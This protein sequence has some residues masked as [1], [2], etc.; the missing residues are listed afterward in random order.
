MKVA[1]LALFILCLIDES[2]ATEQISCL[3]ANWGD[4]AVRWQFQDWEGE[5]T[6]VW[7]I[8]DGSLV[9]GSLESTIPRNEFLATRSIQKLSTAAEIQTC[10][11]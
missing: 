3:M 4:K 8:E 7:R 11:Y 9:A 2:F 5:T 1:A 6:A 10:W